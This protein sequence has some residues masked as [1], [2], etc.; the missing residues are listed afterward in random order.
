MNIYDV[1]IIGAGPAGIGSAL[2]LKHNGFNPLIIEKD[3][4]GGRIRLARKVE[5]LISSVP[6]KGIQVCKILKDVIKRKQIDIRFEEV[7]KIESEKHLY[8][9]NTALNS[10]IAKYIVI[11]TGVRPKIVDILGIDCLEWNKN[12]FFEWDRLR[13]NVHSPVLVIGAGEVGADSACS[14][15]ENGFEVILFSRSTTLRI[16]PSLKI[17]LKKL[18]IK[19]ITGI[20]YKK[21]E[22]KGD[23]IRLFYQKGNKLFVREGRSILLSTGSVPE[24]SLIKKGIDR[25]RIFICGDANKTNYHQSAIAFGDGV[26]TAMKISNLLR[27]EE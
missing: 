14:L 17:D 19:L 9:V 24:L 2:Q 15:K 23:T 26:N 1:I 6:L 13:I 3:E 11:A 22:L 25:S 10:Y 8:I 27:K 16:N 21:I 4:I 18:G 5:N 12:L 20:S 7:L